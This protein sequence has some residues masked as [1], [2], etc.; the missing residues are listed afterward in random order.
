MN[1]ETNNLSI[2]KMIHI[3]LPKVVSVSPLLFIFNSLLFVLDRSFFVISVWRMQI[4]FDSVNNLAQH[5]GSLKSA[6]IALIIYAF[7]KILGQVINGLVNFS[8]EAY[9]QKAYGKLSYTINLKM[10][11]LDPISFENTD[12][13]EK[14]NKSYSGIRASLAFVNT[15]TDIV[16]Q[17]IP[18]F[19]F[20]GIYLF[21]LNSKLI[22]ILPVIFLPVIITYFIRIRVFS[23]LEDQSAP[24][25]RKADYYEKTLVS[26]EYLKET[27]IL[28]AST[29]FIRLFKEALN[30]LNNLNFKAD[31]KINLIDIGT[32]FSSLIGYIAVLW[33]LFGSLIRRQISIGAF[34]AIFASIGTLFGVMEEVMYGRIGEYSRNIPKMK[35]YLEF[36]ELP[37]RQS[38]EKVKNNTFHGDI[39]LKNVSFAYPNTNVKAVENINLTIKKGET[40]AIV[41]E[42]GSGKST[43]IRLIIG[44]YLPQSGEVFHDG[45]STKDVLADNLFNNISGIFQNYQKYQLSLLDNIIISE[46]DNNSNPNKDVDSIIEQANIEINTDKFPDRYNTILSREFNGVDLSIG[47]WQHIAIARGLYRA[48]ELIILDEPTSAIDPLEETKIYEK[49]NKISKDKTTFIVTHRLGSIKFADRILLMKNGSIIGSGTHDELLLTCEFYRNMWES[50]S[51]Y[52]K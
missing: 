28:G 12:T 52:Y 14:I 10:G 2:W 44:L 25:R 49:F 42:N 15:T 23:K 21:K 31:L 30:S 32:R 48:H 35:N 37:G 26:R 6:I 9:D 29:Y 17:Y 45:K 41:G 51:Q 50:Q 46:W 36:L 40:I 16:F 11:K 3:L 24:L 7:V 1:K 43:L 39:E 13:L 34:S 8:A 47:E 20:M 38:Y 19:V 27:R 33:I 5:K 18:Y 22:I 4:L